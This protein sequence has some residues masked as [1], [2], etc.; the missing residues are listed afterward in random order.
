M[1]ARSAPCARL[2]L[3]A[4]FMRL[5]HL[6]LPPLILLNT[7]NLLM[8]LVSPN[9]ALPA[10][11]SNIIIPHAHQSTGAPCASFI[12]FAAISG[13][14]YIAVPH[15]PMIVSE[16]SLTATAKPKSTSFTCPS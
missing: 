9:G 14:T 8:S 4:F 6:I 15:P 13:A 16:S 5:G 12:P 10:I 11:I 2:T 3:A 7:S 1:L